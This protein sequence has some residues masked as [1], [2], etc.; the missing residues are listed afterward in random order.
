MKSL[1]FTSDSK[2][3]YFRYRLFYRMD[4]E[5][6]ADGIK[7]KSIGVMRISINLN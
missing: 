2:D 6:L 1:A 5:K 7:I 4:T 3:I